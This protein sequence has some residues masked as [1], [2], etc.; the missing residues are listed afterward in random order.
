MCKQLMRMQVRYLQS[1]SE[2]E[3]SLAI[4]EPEEGVMQNGNPNTSV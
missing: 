2:P 1:K 4:N 3:D